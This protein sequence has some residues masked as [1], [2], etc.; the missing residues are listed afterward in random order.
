[1]KPW[2]I[3]IYPQSENILACF[4]EI[5]SK[6]ASQPSL[7]GLVKRLFPL[8][9]TDQAHKGQVSVDFGTPL[10]TTFLPHGQSG[11]CQRE[12]KGSMVLTEGSGSACVKSENSVHL[13]KPFTR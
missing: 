10:T 12:N 7:T 3:I 13:V 8:N 6:E 4:R 9:L 1:M 5:P 11:H 2:Q